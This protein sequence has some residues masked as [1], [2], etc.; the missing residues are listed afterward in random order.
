MLQLFRVSKSVENV[1]HMAEPVFSEKLSQIVL[2]KIFKDKIKV[3]G[4]F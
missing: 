2:F 4:T 1:N 3:D